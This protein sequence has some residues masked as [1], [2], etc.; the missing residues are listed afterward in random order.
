MSS[1]EWTDMGM[2]LGAPGISK[3][4]PGIGRVLLSAV[5]VGVL[6]AQGGTARTLAGAILLAAV[7][8]PGPD[9]KSLLQL[10][11]EGLH[12]LLGIWT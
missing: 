12:S 8:L 10:T 4:D 1:E 9:G 2:K 5:I 3:R 11:A 7:A 6:W